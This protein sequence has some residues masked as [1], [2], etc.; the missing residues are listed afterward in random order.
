MI[1]TAHFPQPIAVAVVQAERARGRDAF[2][3][4][5]KAFEELVDTDGDVH[6][7]GKYGKVVGFVD[8]D[9][10]VHANSKYGKVI[11]FVDSDGDVHAGGKY[12]KVIGYAQAPRIQ[13][14]GAAL[15]LLLH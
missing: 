5:I 13:S 14:G 12:G 11:G 10:E 7:G 9:G 1:H 2:A 8:T 15:L 3:Q 4:W 6:A